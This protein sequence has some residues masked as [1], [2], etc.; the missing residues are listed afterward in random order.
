[1]VGQHRSTQRNPAKVVSIEEGKLRHHL[2]K[3]AAEHISW[4]RWMG[5]RLLLR[6]G[7]SVNHK[8]VQRLWRQ[9]GLQRPISRK[10]KRARPA[11][12][13]LRRHRAEHPHQAW[14]M[15]FHFDATADAWP[16]G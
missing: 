2:R 5:Y 11:D 7:L 10:R 16:S 12:G 4:G 14:A 15:D 1:M 13:S 9:E 3:I 6:K 8:R